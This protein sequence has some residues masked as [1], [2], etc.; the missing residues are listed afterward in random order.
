MLLRKGSLAKQS[1][2]GHAQGTT[3]SDS[4]NLRN[5]PTLR[6]AEG[7]GRV[8]RNGLLCFSD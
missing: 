8:V 4:E 6:S 3:S 2:E 7:C 1:A 5:V